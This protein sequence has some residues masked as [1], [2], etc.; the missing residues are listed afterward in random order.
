MQ[1]LAYSQFKRKDIIRTGEVF[2]ALGITGKQERELLSRMARAGLIVRLKRGLYLVP[3]RMPAGGRWGVSEYLL[4]PKLMSEFNGSYQLCGP[5]AF[6]YYGLYDQVP[7]QVYVYN[8]CI[9]GRR[10]IADIGFVF[11]KVAEDRLGATKQIKTP[12]GFAVPIASKARA[13]IDAVYDWRRFNTLPQAYKWIAS[14]L[15]GKPAITDEIIDCSLRFGN[16]ATI[17]RIGYLLD[18]C[19][20]PENMLKRL[21]QALRSSKSLVPYNPG[22]PARGRINRDWGLI[23]N[24]PTFI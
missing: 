23:V 22:S 14:N 5:T 16:Q 21:K 17:R 9:S 6:N 4:L 19:G 3:S 15:R 11:I 7:N 12:E 8:N 13:L 1:L 10:T 18:Q 24:E 20:T 2:P